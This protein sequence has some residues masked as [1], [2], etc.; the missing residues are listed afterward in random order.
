VSN[1]S[2]ENYSTCPSAVGEV[3]NA[4]PWYS[5]TG[6][7]PD[8][9]NSCNTTGLGV[10]NNIG[11]F[12]HARTGIAY[13]A[14]NSYVSTWINYRDYIQAPLGS[15]LQAGKEYCVSFYVNLANVSKYAIDGI[16][17]YF[18]LSYFT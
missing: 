18:S 1:P 13:V 8:Y 15:T 14:V 3:N 4:F 6:G 16:G 12:Q 10:P 5:P 11:G 7:T 2:F 17:S 9:Y